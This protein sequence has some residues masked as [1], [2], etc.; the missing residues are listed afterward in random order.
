[1]T[2]PVTPGGA[3]LVYVVD[4]D[5]SFLKAITRRL[6][7]EGLEV[8]PFASASAFLAVRRPNRPSC[9]VIDLRLPDLDGIVLQRA[10][11]S[12]PDPIPLI[13]LTGHGDV[14]TS[15]EAMKRGAVDF[16]L[17]PV[18]GELLMGAIEA[19]IGRDREA[20]NTRLKQA[21]A[22]TRFALL[23]P[24]E[25]EVCALVVEGLLNKQI[26]F[27]LHMSERTVKAHRAQVM[28]KTGCESVPELVRLYEAIRAEGAGTE[29]PRTRAS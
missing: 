28:Q 17:K 3:P 12:G 1:M 14:E 8:R 2:G 22:R 11:A 27:E 20:R 26:A 5:P 7:A 6:E 24:R 21:D 29:V 4:D 10:V 15:V 25:R 13:F 23:T 9:A 18:P 19:A 16:L